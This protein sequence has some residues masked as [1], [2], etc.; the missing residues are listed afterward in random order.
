MSTAII[1]S[2]SNIPIAP[3]PK[4]LMAISANDLLARMRHI[5]MIKDGI[6][7]L[8]VHYGKPFGGSKE[9]L[10]KPGAEALCV[11]FGLAPKY[12]VEDLSTSDEI[13]YRITCSLY[14]IGSEAYIAAGVGEASSNETKYKWR[15]SV[16]DEEYDETDANRRR[17]LYKKDRPKVLKIKQVRQEPA[18]IGNTVL[19]MCAKRAHIAA[20]L[21][22]TGASDM[23]EQDL[24][25]LAENG[26][27]LDERQSGEP[28]IYISDAEPKTG[29]KKGGGT[30]T[31]YIITSKDGEQ[32]STFHKALYDLALELKK[33]GQPCHIAYKESQYGKD[34]ESM[35]RASAPAPKQ[36]KAAPSGELTPATGDSTEQNG[37]IIKL[38][39]NTFKVKPQQLEAY[40]GESRDKWSDEDRMTLRKIAERITAGEAEVTDYFKS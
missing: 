34:I 22:A 21:T 10:W 30:Y 3:Q 13:R 7:K 8:N 38:F 25:D 9:S 12:T 40:V 24:E 16:C 36:E 11:A 28:L 15:A 26:V 39:G 1:Q 14:G 27:V 29:N 4:E 5:Q 17:I 33:S 37:A 18:D 2:N 35:E 23:F 32:F 31:K 19:K 20:T 6:M